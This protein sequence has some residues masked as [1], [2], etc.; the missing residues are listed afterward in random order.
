MLVVLET[1]QQLTTIEEVDLC[2][3]FGRSRHLEFM[4]TFPADP[5]KEGAW[6]EMYKRW[7]SDPNAVLCSKCP[8]LA[9]VLVDRCVIRAEADA[10]CE[11]AMAI[12]DQK[13]ELLAKHTHANSTLDR[14]FERAWENHHRRAPEEAAERAKLAEQIHLAN[15]IRS[16]RPLLP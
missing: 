8:G 10:R 2:L 16:M 4:A 15:V 9:I 13:R 11:V 1:Y 3:R 14:D 7:A 12:H 5:Q 6:E